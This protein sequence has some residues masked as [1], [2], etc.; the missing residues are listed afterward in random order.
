[1]AY[2]HGPDDQQASLNGEEKSPPGRSPTAAGGH[3]SS[4]HRGRI[5]FFARSA[6]LDEAT[7]GRSHYCWSEDRD[8]SLRRCLE[9]PGARDTPRYFPERSRNNGRGLNT[10]EEVMA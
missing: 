6:C 4:D 10:Y 8:C 2:G 1:M 7:A 5:E 9:G 3:S